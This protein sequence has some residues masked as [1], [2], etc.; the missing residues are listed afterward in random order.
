MRCDDMMSVHLHIYYTTKTTNW[1]HL[2][3]RKIQLIKIII[4]IE[5][6]CGTIINTTTCKQIYFKYVQLCLCLHEV[7]H[8]LSA[9]DVKFIDLIGNMLYNR[10]NLVELSSQT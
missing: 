4:L 3:E 8:D 1:Y 2:V 6:K 9:S 10:R 5:Y 7:A